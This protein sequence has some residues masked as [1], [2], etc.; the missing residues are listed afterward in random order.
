SPGHTLV[1]Q[2]LSPIRVVEVV[3]MGNGS[4]D[5]VPEVR[6][7]PVRTAFVEGMAGCA[8]AGDAF[9][10]RRI[11]RGNGGQ[12]LTV[13]RRGGIPTFSFGCFGLG[14]FG[15]LLLRGRRLFLSC[16]SGIGFLLCGRRFAS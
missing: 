3:Q 11:G 1:G 5:D 7:N 2:S 10:V 15:G 8:T 16:R 13:A 6:T 4:T 9:A 12:Q 14:R